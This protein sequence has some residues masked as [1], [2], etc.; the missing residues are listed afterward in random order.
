MQ[1]FSIQLTRKHV[2][3]FDFFFNLGIQK[4]GQKSNI[5]YRARMQKDFFS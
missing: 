1:M 3:D 5:T 4:Y 2:Y